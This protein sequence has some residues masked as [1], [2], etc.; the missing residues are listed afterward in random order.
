VQCFVISTNLCPDSLNQSQMLHEI[1][2]PILSMLWSVLPFQISL[3]LESDENN[4]NNSAPWSSETFPVPS[5][6]L[7]T[8]HLLSHGGLMVTIRKHCYSTHFTWEETGTK[9]WNNLPAWWSLITPQASHLRGS[10][11]KESLLFPK[12]QYSGMDWI[13]SCCGDA[14]LCHWTYSRAKTVFLWSSFHLAE[15]LA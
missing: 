13:P 14:H 15:R 9:E 3:S 8:S 11:D 10:K 1:P 6:V 12:A 2:T 7:S 5:T 4:L